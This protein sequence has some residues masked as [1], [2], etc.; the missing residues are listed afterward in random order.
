[1]GAG[2]CLYCFFAM[3]LHVLSDDILKWR[4]SIFVTTYS[5]AYNL[6]S[7]NESGGRLSRIHRGSDTIPECSC[8]CIHPRRVFALC[9]AKVCMHIL[10]LLAKR[11]F[12]WSQSE[13]ALPLKH[14]VHMCRCFLPRSSQ[15]NIFQ[16]EFS[17]KFP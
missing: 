16:L 9:S 2:V 13:R 12:C 3:I 15:E 4:T 1:M 10:P 6:G 14:S 17:L 7:G 5:I 8:C 11:I